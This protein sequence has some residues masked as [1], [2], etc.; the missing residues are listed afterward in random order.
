MN[1][2]VIIA[3]LV[4]MAV[5]TA[6]ASPSASQDSWFSDPFFSSDWSDDPFFSDTDGT[7]NDNT[8]DSSDSFFGDDFFGDDFLNDPFFSDDE[9]TENDTETPENDSETDL[10]DIPGCQPDE[11]HIPED[12]DCDGEIDDEFQGDNGSDND[13]DQN[14]SEI[15]E[16]HVTPAPEPS[17]QGEDWIS[18]PNP[19]DHY[20]HDQGIHREGSIK[21]CNILLNQ[22]GEV[23]TGET[24]EDTTFTIDTD[25]PYDDAQP[26]TWTTEFNQVADLVGTSPDYIEGDGYLDAECAEFHD[27]PLDQTYHYGEQTISGEHADEVELVGY[28]EYWEKETPPYKNAEPYNSSE[29]SD[30]VIHLSPGDDNRHAE[31]IVVNQISR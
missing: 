29:L 25:I 9:E 11:V 30:G 24:V 26:V 14:E 20:K 18:Y 19:R 15:E 7:G 13:T 1:Y 2:K 16:R 22:N 23:I 3:V 5:S 12:R 10:G 17:A 28:Q 21:V 27:L 8:D 6:T 4:L 31:I